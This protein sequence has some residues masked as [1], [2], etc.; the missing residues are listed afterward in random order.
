MLDLHSLVIGCLIGVFWFM[1]IY[2]L[3]EFIDYCKSHKIVKK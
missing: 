3:D 2:A 1:M